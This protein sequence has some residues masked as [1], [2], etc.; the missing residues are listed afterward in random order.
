MS[1]LAFVNQDFIDTIFRSQGCPLLV[2][3]SK[4]LAL[5]LHGI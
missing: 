3:E 5:K 2:E 1:E 4:D